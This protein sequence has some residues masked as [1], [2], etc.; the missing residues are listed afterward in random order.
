MIIKLPA[1]HAT[2]WW[3]RCQEDRFGSLLNRTA[4]TATFDLTAEGLA[5]LTQDAEFYAECMH[6]EYT[7]GVDY[8]AAAK[9]LLRRLNIIREAK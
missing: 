7:G 2:D 1:K 4:R 8:S 6:G 9:T 3:E 5:D